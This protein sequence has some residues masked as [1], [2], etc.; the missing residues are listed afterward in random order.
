MTEPIAEARS[1]PKQL[2]NP[3]TL[4]FAPELEREFMAAYTCDSL[5]F[6]RAMLATGL[7]VYCAFGIGPYLLFPEVYQQDWAIRYGVVAPI[8]LLVIAATYIERLQKYWQSGAMVA[9]VTFGLGTPAMLQYLPAEAM[10]V[11]LPLGAQ[12]VLLYTF[13]AVKLRFVY[14]MAVSLAI[15][16]VCV[17]LAFGPWAFP[18]DTRV[19]MSLFLCAWLATGG[20]V[21][22]LLERFSRLDFLR[23]REI[24]ALSEQLDAEKHVAVVANQSKTRFIATAS[25]DLRQPLHAVGLLIDVLRERLAP[26]E[27]RRLAERVHQAVRLLEDQFNGLLDISRL[28]SGEIHI[29]RSRFP[30]ARLAGTLRTKFAPLAEG[31]GLR[32]SIEDTGLWLESDPL[33]L[34]RI[35]ANLVDNAIKYTARGSVTVEAS[36]QGDVVRIAVTD[37]GC[38]IP[39]ELKERVFDEFFRIGGA[40]GEDTRG[41]GIGLAIVRRM[42]ALLSHPLDVRSTVGAG[43]RFTI[44]VPKASSEDDVRAAQSRDRDAGEDELRGSFVLVMDDERQV[45][46]AMAMLLDMWGCNVLCVAGGAEAV[47]A[48]QEHLRDPDLVVC[49]YRLGGKETGLDAIDAVRAAAGRDIPAIILTGDVGAVDPDHIRLRGLA[50]AYK[51]IH[52]DSLRRLMAAHLRAVRPEAEVPA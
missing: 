25:H 42:A 4:A 14:A 7:A 31:K 15:V 20:A 26:G 13:C 28:D 6:V 22:Y 27:D 24:T 23:R 1:G 8:V 10:R 17:W 45:R 49:D 16:A 32:L 21:C 41:L 39:A 43:T 36:A 3:W 52:G 37:T 5:G 48:M 19:I 51:P 34:E 9:M 38:G 50:L 2:Q 33:V 29:A 11:I 35:L 47:E 44:D 12:V 40:A 46:D 18:R 30:M